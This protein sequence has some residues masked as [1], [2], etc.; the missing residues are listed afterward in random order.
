MCHCVY[1]IRFVPSVLQFIFVS[2]SNV[3]YQ[4]II[5]SIVTNNQ[6]NPSLYF[7]IFT[8]LQSLLRSFLAKSTS[9]VCSAFSLS[10]FCKNS[11]WM[12]SS[13]SLPVFGIVPAIGCI[14]A[15]PDLMMS[16]ASGEDP[17]SRY[18]SKSK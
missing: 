10:S 4:T 3:F 5:K 16:C 8:T 11:S 7:S 12:W 9:I 18:D 13:F 17:K 6:R 2:I 15:L 14:S 1:N